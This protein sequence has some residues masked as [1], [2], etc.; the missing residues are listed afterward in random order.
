M[1][2]VHTHLWHQGRRNPYWASHIDPT[3][4]Y[5]DDI[6]LYMQIDVAAGT[7]D[8]VDVVVVDAVGEGGDCNYDHHHDFVEFVDDFLNI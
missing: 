2:T 6:H 1:D 4:R 8:V 7:V 3:Q 5:Q